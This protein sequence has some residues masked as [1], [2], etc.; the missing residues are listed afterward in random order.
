MEDKGLDPERLSSEFRDLQQR[1]GMPIDATERP[2][3]VVSRPACLAVV[4]ARLRAPEHEETLL[5]R[6]RWHYMAGAMIDEPAVLD[7]AALGAG[8][9]RDELRRWSAEPEVLSALEQ[10]MAAARA[11]SPAALALDHKLAPWSG[12]RRYTCP[13][14][15]LS[16]LRDERTIAIPGYQPLA[17][18]EVV[19]ANLCPDLQR[20]EDPESVREVLAWAGEPLATVEV[21]TVAGLD[22]DRARTELAHFAHFQPIGPDGYWA[23]QAPDAAA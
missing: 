14:Y 15:E 12:G 3:L 20:R 23:L 19:V 5:R 18:C 8:L 7:V 4:A 2:R 22:V 17:V 6:L 21:A 13:S 11:P 10:D 1:F 9:D 16:R